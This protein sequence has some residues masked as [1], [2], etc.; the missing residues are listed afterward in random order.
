MVPEEKG[1][2]VRGQFAKSRQPR[3]GDSIVITHMAPTLVR[4]EDKEREGQGG[5][6]ERDRGIREPRE[7][8]DRR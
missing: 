3:H 8:E 7:G 5:D 6:S 1:D 2:G 4:Y